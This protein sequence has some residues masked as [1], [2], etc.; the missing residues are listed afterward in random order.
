MNT[1]MQFIRDAQTIM[2]GPLPTIPNQPI[3]LTPSLKAILEV[4]STLERESTIP[5]EEPLGN[6][7]KQDV[8][9]PTQKLESTSED[10]LEVDEDMAKEWWREV[11]KRADQEGKEHLAP[12]FSLTDDYQSLDE[13]C[14]ANS[15][16]QTKIS[17]HPF[18]SGEYKNG[19]A[20]IRV[21]TLIKFK[22]EEADTNNMQAALAA[23]VTCTLSLG[24]LLKVKPKLL[25]K[26]G[27]HIQGHDLAMAKE[28][29]TTQTKE[30]LTISIGQVPVNKVSSPSRGNEGNTTLPVEHARIISITILDSGAGIS[31][32]T[33]SIWEKW[34]KPT[35]KSSRMNLQ[36]AHNK[37]KNPI[38]ILENVA[39]TS[40]GIEYTR[41][42]A[43]VHFE[44]E[45]NYKLIIGWTLM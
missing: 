22:E 12:P 39:L 34:E 9:K 19:A 33:K 43:L 1:S 35:V 42:F 30:N 28:T 7:D 41:T 17:N 6:Q 14:L 4:S 26:I 8:E 15:L 2:E 37:L 38:G 10:I 29:K 21:P 24:K 36:L 25:E 40:C 20:T 3:K 11:Q 16:N 45:A 18:E 44:R 27:Q 13:I 32:A 5:R 23:K 31:V